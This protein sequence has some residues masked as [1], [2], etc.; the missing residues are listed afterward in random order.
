MTDPDIVF[1]VEGLP[2]EQAHSGFEL[3]GDVVEMVPR[4]G[5]A[6]VVCAEHG[7]VVC[8]NEGLLGIPSGG[9]KPWICG[10]GVCA[11]KDC[12]GCG[13]KGGG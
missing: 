13:G 7:R 4:E 5:E 8:P 11:A 10:V 6:V 12:P 1:D 2:M 9:G 3:H